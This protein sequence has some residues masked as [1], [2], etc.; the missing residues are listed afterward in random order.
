MWLVGVIQARAGTDVSLTPESGR[1]IVV[2]AGFK[3]RLRGVV[4]TAAPDDNRKVQ[5]GCRVESAA[6]M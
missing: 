3:S 6:W 5:W 4:Y 2:S 1:L